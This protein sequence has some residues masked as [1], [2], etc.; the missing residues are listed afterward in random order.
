MIRSQISRL[1]RGV[2]LITA[3]MVM[4]LA[5]ITAVSMTAEQQVYFRR[6]ENILLHE[7]TYLY[8]LSAEDFAKMVL[9]QDFN[10]NK[11]DSLQDIWAT[12]NPPFPVE[13]GILSGKIIDL[14]SKFNINNLAISG[15]VKKWDED[16][17]RRLLAMNNL[18][19]EITNAIIDWLD[20]DDTARF[21]DGAEDVDYLQGDQPYRAGNGMMGSISELIY[22][23]GIDYESYQKLSDALVALPATDVPVNINT[24]SI[25]VLQ[26]L[27][28]GLTEAEAKELQDDLAE[29]PLSELQDLETHP[30][31]K[32]K[33]VDLNGISVE[34]SYFLLQSYAE[35][36]RAKDRMESVI[37]RFNDKNITVVV[38]SQGGL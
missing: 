11:T 28:E 19:P 10:N 37:H 13:G 5:T 25:P 9:Q 7:Q 6:T 23:K 14:Q 32:G 15:K 29:N 20:A 36:G 16:R 1:H 24:A 38:R 30:L 27:I 18:S 8:L 3:L 34:S 22:I 2:A 21:P 17:L 35:V 33:K 4:S 31:V 26:M 12:D